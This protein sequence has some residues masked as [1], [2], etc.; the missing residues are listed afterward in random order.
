[1]DGT[2]NRRYGG[3]GLGLS[4]SRDLATLLGGYISVTSEPGKGSVF[5]LVLPEHYVE[6][7]EHD[8][9]IEQPRQVVAAPAPKPIVVS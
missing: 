9:P 7:T 8:A 5:T 4:I 2:T 3:T 6:R 1:A